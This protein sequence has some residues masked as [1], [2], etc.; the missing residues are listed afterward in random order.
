MDF[1]KALKGGMGL[2][3][4]FADTLI[5]TSNF[6]PNLASSSGS[7]LNGLK[8]SFSNFGDWLFKSSDT[9]KITNFDRLGNILGMGGALYGAYNQQKMAKKNFD[10]QKDAYNFNKYLAQEELRRRKNMENNLQKVWS[11]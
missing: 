3:S 7:F 9:N 11:S 1:I 8:N 10:L 2:G 4:G 5:K 6:T